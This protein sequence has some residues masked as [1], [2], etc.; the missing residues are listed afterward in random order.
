MAIDNVL[1]INTNELFRDEPYTIVG[2]NLVLDR[3]LAE[4]KASS[5]AGP[6]VKAGQSYVYVDLTA[7][8]EP[9]ADFRIVLQIASNTTGFGDSCRYYQNVPVVQNSGHKIY[10]FTWVQGI[11]AYYG[12]APLPQLQVNLEIGGKVAKS[13]YYEIDYTNRDFT[14]YKKKI[15]G[16]VTLDSDEAYTL[17]DIKAYRDSISASADYKSFGLR[18]YKP[19]FISLTNTYGAGNEPDLATCDTLYA[20]SYQT[21]AISIEDTIKANIL[22]DYANGII[23]AKQ[24]D[25]A[26]L[27]VYNIDGDK[28]LDFSQGQILKV[29]DIVRIDKDNNGNSLLKKPNGEPR[30]FQITSRTFR[31]RGVPSLSLQYREVK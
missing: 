27:D 17:F 18:F 21:S 1:T 9:E 3:T 23:T 4:S 29:G 2:G 11:G 12:S 19:C 5:G 8:Q 6:W 14:T 16:I 31:K 10:A 13:E 25:I 26:C 22:N 24:N 30:Y 20:N 28:V 15:S 7:E